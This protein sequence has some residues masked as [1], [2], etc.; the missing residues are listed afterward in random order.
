VKSKFVL[1]LRLIAA[2][3]LLQTLY[4]KFTG[5][6]ESIFIFST[7]G[8]EPWGRWFSGAAELIASV[9]LLIPATEVIGATMAIG[10]MAGAIASHILVLGFVVQDDGGLLFS[11]ACTVF[12]TCS[13]IVFIRRA[14]IPVWIKRGQ[15]FL[16]LKKI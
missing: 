16:Q 2:A 6:P 7:L 5:A 15:D 8:I 14:Q 3:I 10:I 12:V 13:A 1:I 9:L 11:L 4:F